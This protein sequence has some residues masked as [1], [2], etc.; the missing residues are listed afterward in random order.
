VPPVRLRT[1]RRLGPQS[2]KPSVLCKPSVIVYTVRAENMYVL[3]PMPLQIAFELTYGPG[4]LP[5]FAAQ[6]LRAIVTPS[7][8]RALLAASSTSPFSQIPASIIP[9]SAG[10]SDPKHE[11]SN[12]V[13]L[14]GGGLF[15]GPTNF[16]SLVDIG[17]DALSREVDVIRAP[18]SHPHAVAGA[19]SRMAESHSVRPRWHTRRHSLSTTW[20]CLCYSP[21]RH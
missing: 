8:S 3:F 21:D 2:Q 12:R 1:V 19:L 5:I 18:C 17:I 14:T 13:K 15:G 10:A 16:A 9:P 7:I 6:F 11:G 4:A 20:I